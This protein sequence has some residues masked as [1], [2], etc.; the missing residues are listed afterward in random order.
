M[1]DAARKWNVMVTGGAGYVGSCLVPKLLVAGHKVS[2]LDLFIYG[3]D[4]F[5]GVGGHPNLRCVR[6]DMRDPAVVATAL[7]GA[8][9]VIHL[10]C[11]SNDPSFELDPDLGKSINFDCFQPLVRAS[12]AAGVRRFIYASSSSVYGIKQDENV[13]EDL[14]LEPLTDYSKFKAMCEEVLDREREPGFVTLTLRPA[15]VCGYAPRLR[16]DLTVNILTNHAI[17]NGKITVF[18]GAQRRPNINVEDMTD[19]YLRC[20]QYPDEMI[21]GKVFN[22]G[23]ENHTV[24]QI[25]EMVRANVGEA[26]EIVATPTDDNRSYHVSSEKMR[27]ELG[28][29]PRHTIDDAVASLTAAFAAGKV[30]NAMTD[31]VYYNVKLMQEIALH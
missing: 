15:T 29:V 21:D 25:A 20:L 24:M 17:N 23:Y 13:T 12:K 2:V 3:E 5:N 19:L 18:G 10:A 27:R 1:T 16:L 8:D 14:T 9:A 7:D 30:P 6:G 4:V 31:P 11:I 22:A 26:V 28:F